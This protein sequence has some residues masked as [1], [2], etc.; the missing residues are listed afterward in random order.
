M[1]S[2][3][4]Y[5][6][7]QYEISHIEGT[8]SSSDYRIQLK[9]IFS[10]CYTKVQQT[11]T[12]E[13]RIHLLS[14]MYKICGSSAFSMSDTEYDIFCSAAE[15]LFCETK[16]LQSELTSTEFAYLLYAYN[17]NVFDIDLTTPSCS[18]LINT[19][20]HWINGSWSNISTHEALHRIE[21]IYL[22]YPEFIDSETLSATN[23]IFNEYRQK[24]ENTKDIQLLWQLYNTEFARTMMR[25]SKLL[26]TISS[27]FKGINEPEAHSINA[28]QQLLNKAKALTLTA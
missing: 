10:S 16:V 1:R 27:L 25:P 9:D 5:L 8:L 21:I 14:L 17:H 3:I 20:H 11:A 24:V 7:A 22:C 28:R 13:E 2:R 12:I 15:Q 18:L 23:H 19:I 4:Q 26:T 6:I